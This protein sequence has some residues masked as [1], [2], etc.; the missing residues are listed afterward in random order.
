MELAGDKL[1]EETGNCQSYSCG[2]H[3]L[4]LCIEEGLS[5]TAISQA[6][7][8]AKKL[9]T[10]FQHSALATAELRRQQEA[11]SVE[12][13][14]LQLACITRWNSALYMIQSILHNRWPLTAVLADESV[15]K[16][17]Y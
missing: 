4:Q 6:L 16:R 2:A 17:Q 11:M 7:G 8:V 10:H 12:P 3:W 9:V 5:L 13:K 15:T 14:K 1:H